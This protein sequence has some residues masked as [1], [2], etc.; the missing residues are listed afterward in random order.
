MLQ[1]RSEPIERKWRSAI[2]RKEEKIGR[3]IERKIK[4][5]F[6]GTARHGASSDTENAVEKL[7]KNHLRRKHRRDAP[8]RDCHRQTSE[9]IIDD[10]L[11]SAKLFVCILLTLRTVVSAAAAATAT[12]NVI[13]TETHWSARRWHYRFRFISHLL[14]GST[15][16][17]PE[18]DIAVFWEG[19]VKKALEANPQALIRERSDR[20]CLNET[21]N[22]LLI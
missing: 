22:E 8:R 18:E 12:A 19:A 15:L 1:E 2:D 3:K 6:D 14:F 21:A 7:R 5:D 11:E 13:I 10:R 9:A 20:R 4:D 17:H 16:S